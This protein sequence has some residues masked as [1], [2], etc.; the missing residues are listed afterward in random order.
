[1]SK[2][3]LILLIMNINIINSYKKEYEIHPGISRKYFIKY[4]ETSFKLNIPENSDLQINIHSINCYIGIT[5]EK[6]Y[7]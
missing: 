4:E 7:Y 3:L 6:K 5:P 2:L 1:M